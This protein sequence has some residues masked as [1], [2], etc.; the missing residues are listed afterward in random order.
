MEIQFNL[1]SKI[2]IFHKR[3]SYKFTLNDLASSLSNVPRFYEHNTI[4]NKSITSYCYFIIKFKDS[5]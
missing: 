3:D 5:L 4:K 1:Y 2:H